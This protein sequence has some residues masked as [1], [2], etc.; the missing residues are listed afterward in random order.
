MRKLVA[1]S[2]CIA[3]FGFA[4]VADAAQIA[5]P[6]I[7]GAHTQT[8]ALCI[9]YNGGTTAL[10]VTLRILN[11]S[12]GVEKSEIGTLGPGQ[13]G[14]IFTGIA[15]GVAYACSATAS[16]V[17]TLRATMIIVEHYIEPGGGG[18]NRSIRSAPLR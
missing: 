3:V 16:Q 12:G 2:A 10:T 4:G 15:F 14:S 9:V 5:S 8:G 18:A 6:A 17:S 13:F 1:L 11:E 7:F